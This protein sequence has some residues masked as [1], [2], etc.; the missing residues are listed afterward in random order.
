MKAF[1]AI[2]LYTCLLVSCR[3]EKRSMESVSPDG[4]SRVSVEGR[5]VGAI[6]AWETTV[7]ARMKGEEGIGFTTQLYCSRLDSSDVQFNW[8]P[9]GGECQIVFTEK[10]G[11]LRRFQAAYVAGRGIYVT[12]LK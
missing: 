1:P 8:Q 5:R 12:E 2:V 4:T 6:S 7:L 11:K 9:G 3:E 10:D